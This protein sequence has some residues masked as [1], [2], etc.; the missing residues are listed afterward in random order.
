MLGQPAPKA[1]LDENRAL[2][3]AKKCAAN[4]GLKCDFRVFQTASEDEDVGTADMLRM[5]SDVKVC[6]FRRVSFHFYTAEWGT[7]YS[8]VNMKGT[9]VSGSLRA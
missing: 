3:H 5:L 7:G 6:R 8:S 2:S 1:G 9:R 4:V